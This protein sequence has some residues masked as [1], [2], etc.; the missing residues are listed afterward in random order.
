MALTPEQ[1]DRLPKAVQNHIRSLEDKVGHL[2]ERLSVGPED[3]LVFADP[4]GRPPR[5]LGREVTVRFAWG[6]PPGGTDV[7]VDVCVE[8]G[9]LLVRSDHPLVVAPGAAN[10]LTVRPITHRILRSI[11]NANQRLID[12]SAPL[13]GVPAQPVDDHATE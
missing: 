3:S 12:E 13:R 7:Y 1:L 8:D 5:P 11:D 6:T 4:Y 10:N 9:A 2:T